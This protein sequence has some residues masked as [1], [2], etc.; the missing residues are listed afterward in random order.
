MSQKV[1]FF[2]KTTTIGRKLKEGNR[3]NKWYPESTQEKVPKQQPFPALCTTKGEYLQSW[4]FFKQVLPCVHTHFKVQKITQFESA[5]Q[6]WETQCAR[7]NTMTDYLRSVELLTSGPLRTKTL[8]TRQTQPIL[9]TKQSWRRGVN[10]LEILMCNI[11]P[12]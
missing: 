11:S 3:T 12:F 4:Y 2:L 8:E 7:G 6:Y 10:Q 5:Q 9:L 1:F